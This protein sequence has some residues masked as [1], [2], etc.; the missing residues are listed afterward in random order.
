M[1]KGSRMSKESRQKM[2]LRKKGKPSHFMGKKHSPEVRARMSESRKAYL[3]RLNPDY[4]YIPNPKDD[5]KWIRRERIKIFGG[6]H[7]V[8]E[9]EN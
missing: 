9:W 8:G 4:R 6:S 7:S 3:K 5:R 1:K 2:S